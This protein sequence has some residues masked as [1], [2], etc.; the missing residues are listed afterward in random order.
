MALALALGQVDRRELAGALQSLDVRWLLLAIAL[1]VTVFALRA[2]KWRLLLAR[3]ADEQTP[4]PRYPAV[5]RTTVIGALATDVLP[6]RLDEL[7]R[8]HLMGRRAGLPRSRVLGTIAVERTID[9]F[10]LLAATLTLM[11][12]LAPTWLP[13]AALGVGGLLACALLAVLF[14]YGGWGVPLPGQLGEIAD[15]IL[16]GMRLAGPRAPLAALV[17]ALE[18]L[19]LLGVF[20]AVLAAGGLA[21]P[22]LA[23]LLL[24]A[25]FLVFAVPVSPGAVGI[26]HAAI[27]GALTAAGVPLATAA[28]LGVAAHAIVLLPTSLMGAAALSSEGLSPRALLVAARRAPLSATP[29]AELPA[30]VTA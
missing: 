7:V 3:L 24:V 29:A 16:G 28:A 15:E 8:A 11:P 4:V 13:V 23:L 2:A 20:A 30:E 17:G 12:L 6:L 14:A 26:Y 27:T 18:W 21:S 25:S 10:W 1:D 22:T 5:F 9:L 19:T